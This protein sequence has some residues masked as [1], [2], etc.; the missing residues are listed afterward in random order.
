MDHTRN[1]KGWTSENRLIIIKNL[2]KDKKIYKKRLLERNRQIENFNKKVEILPKNC[3]LHLVE[4]WNFV[5][6]FKMKQAISGYLEKPFRLS[7]RTPSSAGF[8]LPPHC[9]LTFPYAILIL[10]IYAP[11]PSL[12]F[13]FA[14]R[15]HLTNVN[16]FSAPW[17]SL[18]HGLPRPV[19]L[20][21]HWN[22]LEKIFTSGAY[23][24][25]IRTA[26]NQN[27]LVELN[28]TKQSVWM[29]VSPFQLVFVF[30]H[31]S[32]LLPE[33]HLWNPRR[34]FHS[35]LAS[36][37]CTKSQWRGLLQLRTPDSWHWRVSRPFGKKMRLHKAVN[38]AK[39]YLIPDAIRTVHLH[40]TIRSLLFAKIAIIVA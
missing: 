3:I 17:S 2:S 21:S 13:S 25:C 6:L 4:Y 32:F 20:S 18:P 11:L 22:C 33:T 23:C 30:H 7:P 29:I 31:K 5:S 34:L 40:I 12:F 10:Q 28:Y 16:S 15:Y 14:L 19:W 38:I 27:L 8:H 36:F 37:F 35:L 1:K 9:N 39:R 26:I 24:I